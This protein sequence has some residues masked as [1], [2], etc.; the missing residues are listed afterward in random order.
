M[1][2]VKKQKIA[3][4]KSGRIYRCHH[5]DG[6]CND[7]LSLKSVISDDVYLGR[8]DKSKSK[9]E[10]YCTQTCMRYNYRMNMTPILHHILQSYEERKDH[11]AAKYANVLKNPE[12]YTPEEYKTLC[13]ETKTYLYFF[14][15]GVNFISAVLQRKSEYELHELHLKCLHACGPSLEYFHDDSNTMNNILLNHTFLK[16]IMI[17]AFAR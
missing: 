13:D 1:A 3:D 4:T 14:I 7:D 17:G 11:V 5:C 12:N 15:H 6:I 9:R 10:Y 8:I 2:S 16:N